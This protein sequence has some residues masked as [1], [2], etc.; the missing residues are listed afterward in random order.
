[1]AN[2]MVTPVLVADMALD[3]MDN[4]LKLARRVNRRHEGTFKGE[5]T[6]GVLTVPKPPKFVVQD[7]PEISQAQSINEGSVQ[8]NIN[9]WKTVLLN[10]TGWDRSLSP[11]K[12]KTFSDLIVKPAASQLANYIELAI[13]A[14]YYEI[15]NWCGTA[16]DPPD[17]YAD[18]AEIRKILTYNACPDE[19]RTLALTPTAYADLGSGLHNIF[20]PQGPIGKLVTEAKIP[21]VAGLDIIESVHCPTHTV[22]AYA[23]SGHVNGASQVGSS[24]LTHNWTS[25]SGVF[26]KG[27]IFTIAAVYMINPVTKAST[28]ELQTFVVTADCSDTAGATTIPIYPA[29]ITSGANQTVSGSPADAAAITLKGTASTAYGQNIAFHKNA[30][31]LV[32]VPPVPPKAGVESAVRNYEGY[33]IAISE[34]SD[35]MKYKTIWRADILFGTVTFWPELAVRVTN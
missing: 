29:I 26:K 10:L 22:G 25:G 23:G 5:D 11:A 1:M 32:M 9:T 34:G 20:N 24:L 15:A 35:I 30:F 6:G 13:L 8:I 2:T 14:R 18:V 7:G 19:D 27:D 4:K 12:L 21:N 31:G 28:G 16:G 3:Y 33:A 17:A